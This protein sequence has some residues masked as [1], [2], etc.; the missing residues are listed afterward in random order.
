MEVAIIT[1]GLG[2]VLFFIAFM[3][4]K[5]GLRLG[6]KTAKGETPPSPVE[7]VKETINKVREIKVELEQ[8]KVNKKFEEDMAQFMN[9]TG[10]V[11]EKQ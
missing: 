3:G 11:E 1:V 7:E 5:Q 10:D 8:A 2:G 6:I 9:Y 4:F